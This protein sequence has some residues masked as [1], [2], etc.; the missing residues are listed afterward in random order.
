M[1]EVLMPDERTIQTSET[2]TRHTRQIA[3]MFS[4]CFLAQNGLIL[5]SQ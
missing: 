3:D 5:L 4:C 1:C 2:V